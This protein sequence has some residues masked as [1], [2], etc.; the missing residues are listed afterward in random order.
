MNRIAIPVF[1]SRVSPVLDSCARL[2]LVDLDQGQEITRSEIL[3]EGL[4][5]IDRLKILKRSGVSTVICGGIS[6]GFYKM[7][8]NAEIALIIGIAGE[9]N[10]V[11]TAYC[12]NRLG[13]PC[14]CMPGYTPPD[15][16]SA[17]KKS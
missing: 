14:F 13:E 6:D 10:Q 8:S 7:I 4:S 5:E 11:L 3:F 2:L 9:V 17:T 12:C 1:K 15:K 16:R